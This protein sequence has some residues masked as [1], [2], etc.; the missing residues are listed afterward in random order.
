M[1]WITLATEDALSEAVGRQLAAEVQLPIGESLRREGAGY[2]RRCV[3]NFC[4]IA[5]QRPVFMLTDLDRV[6]CASALI[7]TWL[8]NQPRP[9]R[10]VFRVVVREIESWLLADHR[11]MSKLFGSRVSK[12]PDCPDQL[13]DP[14][15]ALLKLA[16]K[17]NRDIRDELLVKRDA[18]ASQGLGYNARLSAV[19]RE[20][21][22]PSRAAQL[23][24]SLASA[25]KRL[26]ELA[27]GLPPQVDE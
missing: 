16:E 24:P 27:A 15:R 6:S 18:F 11:A 20:T 13:E 14:K 26:L 9:P 1:N 25:R 10:F 5:A 22:S 19:V 21:W 23:S 3:P 17:A 7:S 4:K 2:L 12:L 8:G